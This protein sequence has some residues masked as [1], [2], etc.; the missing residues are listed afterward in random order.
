[1]A[2]AANRRRDRS[3]DCRR[4]GQI[5]RRWAPAGAPKHV[6]PGEIHRR[7]QEAVADPG[8]DE[9]ERSTMLADQGVAAKEQDQMADGIHSESKDDRQRGDGEHGPFKATSGTA[10]SAIR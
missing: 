10:R 1:M 2:Q 7:Q 6:S 5:A 4:R 9:L 3:G 8:R